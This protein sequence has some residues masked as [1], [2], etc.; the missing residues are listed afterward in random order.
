MVMCDQVA[1]AAV[2]LVCMGLC[3]G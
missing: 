1:L 2:F 3:V